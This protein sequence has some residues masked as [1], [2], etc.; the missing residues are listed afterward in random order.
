[1]SRCM[2]SYILETIINKDGGNDTL[3][4]AYT[5]YTVYTPEPYYTVS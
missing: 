3:W 2:C 4:T 5:L 1:M